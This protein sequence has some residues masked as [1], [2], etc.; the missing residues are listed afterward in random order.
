MKS[1]TPVFIQYHNCEQEKCLPSDLCF[2]FIEDSLRTKKPEA[3]NASGRVLMIGG[4]GKPRR[5]FLWST[6][7]IEK[8]SQRRDGFNV[9]EGTGWQL[10]PPVELRGKAFDD[11]KASCANFIGFRR[12]D[13][14]PYCTT[15]S[16]HATRGYPPGDPTQLS[17]FLRKLLPLFSNESITQ[18]IN[19]AIRRCERRLAKDKPQVALS[20]RQPYAEAIMR[21]IKKIEYR[22]GPTSRRGRI[23][24]YASKKRDSAEEERTWLADHGMSD[25]NCDVLPRGVL[26]GSVEIFRCDGGEW[27]LRNPI[28]AKKLIRPKRQPQPVWFYPF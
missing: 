22:S 23:L 3:K 10:C 8:F 1:I 20:I 19:S 15:L 28:P 26:I 21:G 17:K 12:I 7:T 2:N 24:I 9:L 13:E 16:R 14:L 6:F 18:E 25:V 11:F 4:V 5:Y 27:H